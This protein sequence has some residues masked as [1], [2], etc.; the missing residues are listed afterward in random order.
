[1]NAQLINAWK[2]PAFR[3]TLSESEMATLA[4]NP[5]GMIE[6]SMSDLDGIAG[7]GGNTG[8]GCNPCGGGNG[9]GG[10]KAKSKKAK[11]NKGK[12]NRGGSNRKG[13]G[14]GW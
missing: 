4:A 7:G 3:A 5:A 10:S 11:S 1:M 8:G 12:S 14:C 6:L 9:G 13:N 2:N